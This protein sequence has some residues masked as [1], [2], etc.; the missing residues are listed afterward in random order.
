M[1]RLVLISAALAM[2]C[3]A[4]A[5]HQA[6]TQSDEL[7]ARGRYL[8]E[9]AGKC[10][11]CHGAKLQGGTLDFLNPKLPPIV[12]RSAPKIAGLRQ[13]ARQDAVTFL[14]TGKLPNGK[15]ARPPMPQYRFDIADAMAIV[16]YLKSLP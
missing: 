8:V 15:P 6:P 13:L 7:V 14:N 11:D 12:Q 3:S 10:S 16:A 9:M 1:R 2:V 5:T 4:I